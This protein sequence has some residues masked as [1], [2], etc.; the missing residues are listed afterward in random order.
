MHSSACAT[1]H[2]DRE[3]GEGQKQERKK[4]TQQKQNT[5][6]CHHATSTI[7]PGYSSIVVSIVNGGGRRERESERA[8]ERERQREREREEDGW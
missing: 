2:A 4:V 8:R 1:I 7:L 6:T 5:Q 3:T